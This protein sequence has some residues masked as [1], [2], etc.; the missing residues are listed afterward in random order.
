[1]VDDEPAVAAVVQRA[2]ADAGY[3]PEVFGSALAAWTQFAAAPARYDLLLLDH[4]MPDL[5][6]AEFAGRA[7]QLAAAL[8]IVVMTGRIDEVEPEE[9]RRLGRIEVLTKP[10]VIEE[11]LVQVAASL[12]SQ[13]P[14]T[15][16]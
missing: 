16:G 10:F 9:L 5:T 6:G 13:S 8:P 4:Q 15:P 1:V 12:Q 7:R 3:S 11:L 14:T 2:L